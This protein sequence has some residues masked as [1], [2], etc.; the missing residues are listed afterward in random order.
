MLPYIRPRPPIFCWLGPRAGE[1]FHT[2][3]VME[4][5]PMDASLLDIGN[6]VHPSWTFSLLFYSSF[7]T[8]DTFPSTVHISQ[9]ITYFSGISEFRS[10]FFMGCRNPFPIPFPHLKSMMA[11][12]S[13]ETEKGG[14]TN[15]GK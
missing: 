3:T 15:K 1:F 8:Y 10:F 14:W 12:V 6:Q 11:A 2:H 4:C 7:L 9:T 13:M 5:Q